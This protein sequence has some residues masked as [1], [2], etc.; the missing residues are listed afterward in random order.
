MSVRKTSPGRDGF[1]LVELLTSAVILAIAVAAIVAVVRKGREMQIIDYHRRQARVEIQQTFESLYD[2]RKY[3]GPDL[4]AG[5]SVVIDE[6]QEG[7][8]K[9]RRRTVVTDDTVN[10]SGSDV[11]VRKITVTLNWREIDGSDESVSLSKWISDA[12]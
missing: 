2:Y 4:L 7:V 3:P 8:L 12:L 9:A 10:I 11:P 6:R 1:T 5:D